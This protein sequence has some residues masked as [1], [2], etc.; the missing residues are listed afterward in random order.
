MGPTV[1]QLHVTRTRHTLALFDSILLVAQP[2]ST[3]RGATRQHTLTNKPTSGNFE[4]GLKSRQSWTRL[5]RALLG[6]PHTRLM[7]S[8][9]LQ[10]LRK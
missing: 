5:G 3:I 7:S 4:P 1:L 10:G 8:L 9:T 2:R 6:W